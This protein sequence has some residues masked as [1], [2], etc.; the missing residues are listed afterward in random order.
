MDW[1]EQAAELER[2]LPECEVS[3]AWRVRDQVSRLLPPR[4]PKS[5][6]KKLDSFLIEA[7]A[8]AQRCAKILDSLPDIK[9]P[10]DLPISKHRESIRKTI[11]ENQVVVI[12][13]ETGSGKTTQ[14]P[15]LCLDAGLGVR[16]KIACT[17]PRR[18]AALSVSQRVAE[19]LKVN[20]GREV[21]AKIRFTD[22]TSKDTRIKFLTDGMLLSEVHGDRLLLE[23]D[24]VIIDEAHERSLNIDFLLGYLNQLRKERPDLKIIITSATI[25]TESFSKAFDDA[26][27]IEV[28]GRMFPVELEYLPL[29]EL[30]SGGEGNYIDGA[31]A[32]VDQLIEEYP[33]GDILVFFPAEK[34]IRETKEILE[35]RRWKR[36]EICTLFG[37][38]SAG[39]QQKVFSKSSGRKVILA[40]N[41]AETSLTIPGIRFV[42]DTGYARL[43]RYNSG[44]R[45]QRLPIESVSQSSANQRMGR[46]GRVENGFCIRL[47]SENDFLK[48]PEYTQA[49]IL[50]ANLAS[51]ILRMRVFELGDIETFPFIDPPSARA[52]ES[53]YQLL[54]ELGAL[55]AKVRTQKA[56]GRIGE[57]EKA[58]VDASPERHRGLGQ[59]RSTSS[60][61]GRSTSSGQGTRGERGE[62]GVGCPS[63]ALRAMEG[64]QVSGRNSGYV[65]TPLGKQL[66]HLPVDP[67]VGRMILEAKNE[68]ALE[69]V[70]II[71]AGLSIQD[72]RER[73]EEKREEADAM[74]KK[75]RDDSSDFITL[76][77]IWAAYH[78][79][80][81]K[82]TQNQLRKFCKSHYLSYL[83]MRE[84]R[85][86]HQQLVLVMKELREYR[87]SRADVD[88]E[89]IHRSIVAGL[90]SNVCLKDMGNHYRAARNRKAMIFPGSGLFDK[91]AS[92]ELRKKNA[93]A[94][95]KL[96]PG[97]EAKMIEGNTPEWI[98]AS[99]IVETG[100]VYARTVAGI[101]PAWLPKLGAHL[102]RQ[103]YS[104]PVWDEKG[105]RV[106]V[107]QRS[108]LLGLEVEVKRVG[109]VK[110][111]PEEATD[112]FIREGLLG[113]TIRTKLKFREHN[114][115]VLESVEQIQA[116]MRKSGIFGLE[117]TLYRFY[118]Q[119][120]QN[121]GSVQDLQG[122]L[123]THDEGELFISENELIGGED[124]GL[125]P[126]EFPRSI[127]TPGGERSIN[128]V[129]K[130]G[131]ETDGA[132][133]RLPMHAFESFT[134]GALD[135][136]V[137]GYLE[138]KV[139]ALLRGLP[140][141]VRRKLFPIAET[142]NE[143]L[144]ILEPGDYSLGES[145]SAIVH[146]KYG[147]NIPVAAWDYSVIPDHL[148]VRIEVVNEKNQ[149]I[150]S[151]RSA[152][153]I[154][155]E[156]RQ[157]IKEAEVQHR[158]ERKD[159]DAWAVAQEKWGLSEL[160]TWDFG[161]LPERVAVSHFGG[162]PV[163]GYPGLAKGKVACDIV[164]YKSREEADRE[165]RKAMPHLLEEALRYEL[166]WLQKELRA[167]KEL[168]PLCVTF[169]HE[170]TLEK[171]AYVHLCRH[172]YRSDVVLPLEQKRF[173]KLQHRIRNELKGL[174]P[175]FCDLLELIF[176]ERQRMSVEKRGYAGMADD[177]VRLIPNDF[178]VTTPY[179]QLIEYPRYLKA[180][181]IRRER[182]L[183]DP[184]K[185]YKRAEQL[186]VFKK[187][188]LNWHPVEDLPGPCRPL[189]QQLRWMLEELQVSLFAQELRT[190]VAISPSKVQDQIDKISRL[191][192]PKSF[193]EKI[194]AKPAIDLKGFK[195]GTD[196]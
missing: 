46:C 76:Y 22:K 180:M 162:V 152:E 4:N 44:T 142:A 52:I 132:T 182:Y 191:V 49:E 179:K 178:L 171:H 28:S 145:L 127:E 50:R 101:D 21:G 78:D 80:T 57:D 108:I 188:Y 34:D 5:V 107:K 63:V 81:E 40:T 33:R 103:K 2:L 194:K 102:I 147:V 56:E 176:K 193:E 36:V 42:V 96:T 65:L 149:A 83:R 10:E 151:A 87:K 175:T 90:L 117:E 125:D 91:K 168:A 9:F 165:T 59:G 71:A 51:V 133:L 25:D 54:V 104:D 169:L 61:Q 129:Y 155:S 75:F 116:R 73:P 100:Q 111:N 17:Q 74:H 196:F 58:G 62:G 12:A 6:E 1:K 66:A 189:V 157:R 48:R 11:Q 183:H 23:Y 154:S 77:N 158:R 163:F 69:E 174:V 31:A 19:E 146:E 160:K 37:R 166:A 195:I 35:G 79:E 141:D 126:Q 86:I 89:A 172:L 39:D 92:R 15:K 137:P 14:L 159:D 24:T 110:S 148:N 88:Y 82:L 134:S 32:A 115:K 13:G 20:W 123:K 124:V 161:D 120:I 8:S 167:V 60:G 70:L 94:A 98:V 143:I 150:A 105:E 122:W 47:Y 3:L 27:I 144:A 177:L 140:K 153:D 68:K 29:D 156:V 45:T 99:E 55:R 119:R 72:P 93:G 43:S 97:K 186:N 130:P 118:S 173:E 136:I 131:E 138:E 187:Q 64:R 164:L 114:Q 30:L 106:L 109:Y 16:G 26:P 121:V 184:Q 139:D 85:D 38:L 128:Y 181:Q 18:I 67:T 7:K 84:W 185:D 95:T 112:L 53:G 41:I 113:D 190:A 192:N 135:W 170:D